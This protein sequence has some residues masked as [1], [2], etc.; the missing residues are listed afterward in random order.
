MIDKFDTLYDCMT[1][2]ILKGISM[3]AQGESAEAMSVLRETLS[4]GELLHCYLGFLE[5]NG[6][7]QAEKLEPLKL[8]EEFS[9]GD[10]REIERLMG[11]RV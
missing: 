11:K 9:A 3:C 2:G 8:E 7:R 5:E 1:A 4:R 10:V 6:Q